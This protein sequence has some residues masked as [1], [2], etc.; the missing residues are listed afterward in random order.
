[1][2]FDSVQKVYIGNQ[3]VTKTLLQNID[4]YTS[5]P[6]FP[7]GAIAFWKLADLTD[8]SGNGNN[9]VNT[10]NVQFV[11]G[12]IGN[13]AQWNSPKTVSQMLSRSD[14]SLNFGTGDFSCSFW[15]YPFTFTNDPFKNFCCHG[16]QMVGRLA[17]FIEQNGNLRF[18]TDLSVPS[19]I[20]Q[21]M[22][23]NTWNHIA[24]TRSSGIVTVYLNNNNIGQF[25][26]S[27]SIDSN[28]Y[29]GLF[30]DQVGTTNL[31]FEGRM[32]AIGVWNRA[33]TLQEI[34]TLYNNG[35]GLEP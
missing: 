14:N 22:S 19:Q 21:S 4:L 2:I 28:F 30:N 23:F 27:S 3:E 11:A 35:N 24:Y 7:A 12:K 33:L 15:V 34:Q 13:C 8:S 18:V 5:A 32:D 29:I 1:M 6:P 17:P 20:N 31:Q 16:S 10:N 26:Y 25:N 9:L